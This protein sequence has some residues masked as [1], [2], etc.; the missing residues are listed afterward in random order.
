MAG[1]PVDYKWEGPSSSIGS[2]IARGVMPP[3]AEYVARIIKNSIKE[4]NKKEEE[5]QII[6]FRKVPEQATLL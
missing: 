3:V 1:F 2:Q 4:K 5:L 6:D